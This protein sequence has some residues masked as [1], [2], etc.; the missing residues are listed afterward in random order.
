MRLVD[1]LPLVVLTA[2]WMAVPASA[3]D[4]QDW[5]VAPYGRAVQIADIAKQG[6][7]EVSGL[8]VSRQNDDLLWAINDSGGGTFLHALGRDGRAR[9]RVRVVGVRNRDWEDLASF[10]LEGNAYLLIADVGDN[11]SKH[12]SSILY[13]LKEPMLHGEEFA[14]NA[15]AS[16]SRVIRFRY[17]E[18]PLDCEAVAVDA[19]GGRILL[20]SKRR[21]P[22]LLFELPLVPR[23]PDAVVVARRVTEVPHL[24]RPSPFLKRVLGAG[25]RSLRHLAFSATSVDVAGDGSA[26]AVLT[27]GHAFL[28]PR[29]TD[30]SWAEVFARPPQRIALPRLRQAEALAFG[31]DG[32]TLY[33]TSEGRSAPLLRLDPQLPRTETRSELPRLPARLAETTPST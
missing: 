20:L 17:D 13:V 27:Y 33:I 8:A 2:V 28:F 11:R 32:H 10:E 26:A 15:R 6:L 16:L 23:G 1:R 19:S 22:T 12:R 30:E 29:S 7:R 9:G 21:V 5:Q 24:P 14:K 3:R 4:L 31:S 18:G 25:T